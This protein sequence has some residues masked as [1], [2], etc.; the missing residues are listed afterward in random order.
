M[1][2]ID[3]PFV[4]FLFL[5]LSIFP[6][7]IY[8]Q[9]LYS[10]AVNIPFYDDY[11]AILSFLNRWKHLNITDKI[12]SLL[13]QHNEHRI[14]SSRIIY[15]SYFEFFGNINFKHLLLIGNL[16]L[17]SIALFVCLIFF[18]QVREIYGLF[19]FVVSFCLFDLSSYENSIWTMA[20][21]ANYGIIM[22]FL[23]SIYYYSK[24]NP[25][26]TIIALV[27]QL[28][29]MLSNGNGA[30]AGFSIILFN[31]LNRD[32]IKIIIS[33]FI[34]IIGVYLYFKGYQSSSFNFENINPIGIFAFLV[35][36]FGSH[37]CY[38]SIIRVLITTVTL[39]ILSRW[40]IFPIDKTL[41]SRF[42]KNPKILSVL[43]FITASVVVT[44]IFRSQGINGAG[45]YSS[46]YLIY[47]H[48]Y[49]ILIFI[50]TILISKK[51]I[52]KNS[53]PISWAI[54]LIISF[55]INFEYGKANL[56]AFSNYHK[57]NKYAFPGNSI[58]A[59]QIAI[60]SC[61]EDIYCR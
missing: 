60:I 13:D 33:I 20:S 16:Q 19:I 53:L 52:L 12:N 27:C 44:A 23:M 25:Y 15:A 50:V 59:E 5:L 28:A 38:N 17:L 6:I 22:L 9:T 34:T 37:F 18:D 48:L 40:L 46:R 24:K 41:I 56:T 51:R 47:A 43:F 61:E 30:I 54:V 29:C 7:Y 32:R 14:F 49:T 1:K 42:Y 2:I 45:S 11:D 21:V 35:K 4:Q 8:S 3:K 36:F 26:L 10:H 39:I 31:V 55:F 58:H 57:E